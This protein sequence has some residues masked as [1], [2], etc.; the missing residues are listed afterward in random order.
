MFFFIEGGGIFN[1]E[2]FVGVFVLIVNFIL[3]DV[4]VIEVGKLWMYFGVYY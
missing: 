1:C 4:F 3:F 2:G